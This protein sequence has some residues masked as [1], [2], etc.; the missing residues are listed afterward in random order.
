MG[1][2]GI[3]FKYDSSKPD[4]H[5]IERLFDDVR[6]EAAKGIEVDGRYPS[7]ESMVPAL[8]DAMERIQYFGPQEKIDG[9]HNI[10][11]NARIQNKKYAHQLFKA[12][13]SIRY[14]NW[15]D[16][17]DRMTNRIRSMLKSRV[18]HNA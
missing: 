14:R 17:Y 2:E 4:V 3:L 6:A 1:D 13:T 9:L 10:W 7:Y 18:E 5:T 15:L 11:F 8:E 12:E 16:E